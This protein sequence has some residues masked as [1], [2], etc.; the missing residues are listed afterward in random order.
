MTHQ[1]RLLLLLLAT[2][3]FGWSI[4]EVQAQEGTRQLMPPDGSNNPQGTCYITFRRSQAPNFALEGARESDRLHIHLKAGEKVYFGMKLGTGTAANLSFRFKD[5]DGVDVTGFARQVVPTNAT[6]GLNNDPGYIDNYSQAITGPNGITKNGSTI[7]TGYTPRSF[8]ATKTGDYYIEFQ[9]WNAGSFGSVVNTNPPAYNIEFFDITVTDG[10]DVL[11]SAPGN[12]NESV[13]RLWSRNW[14]LSSNG[15]N[16]FISTEF[17]VYT[18][19]GFVNKFKAQ[20]AP[21]V[22]T[23]VSNSFGTN[24][25]GDALFNRK[26]FRGDAIN[27]AGT[28]IAEH[29]I[30]LNDPDI[31]V[32]PN[33]TIQP[34]IKVWFNQVLLLDFDYSRTPQELPPQPRCHQCDEKCLGRLPTRVYGLV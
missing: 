19:D 22:F 23:V 26:S 28:D 3:L 12:P 32:Y 14:G 24:R 6:A 18:F 21:F 8:T 31:S 11:V 5:P 17:F 33:S 10:N 9:T 7:T 25:T 2:L 20:M 29:K 4:A 13:G 15:F 1:P 27:R 30:F 16:N 34:I